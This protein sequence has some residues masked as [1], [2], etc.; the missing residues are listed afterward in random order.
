MSNEK[1]LTNTTEKKKEGEGTGE[2][3]PNKVSPLQLFQ[4]ILTILLILGIIF[5]VYRFIET[6]YA[7]KIELKKVEMRLETLMKRV[8]MRLEILDIS[9]KLEHIEDRICNLKL[10][11]KRD[12]LDEKEIMKLESQRGSLEK[13]KEIL[14]QSLVQGIRP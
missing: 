2:P 9:I 3:F 4:L 5:S 14:V 11:A 8:E 7:L 6:R 12:H 1:A 10:K 13:E